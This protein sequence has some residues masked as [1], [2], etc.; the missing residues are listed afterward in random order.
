MKC[1]AR[2]TAVFEYDKTNQVSRQEINHLLLRDH[3][4]IPI[5]VYNFGQPSSGFATGPFTALCLK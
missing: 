4:I 1:C 3:D 2:Q 5:F